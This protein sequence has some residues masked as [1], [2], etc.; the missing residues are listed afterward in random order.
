MIAIKN[1][2]NDDWAALTP[3]QQVEVNCLQEKKKCSAAS[4]NAIGGAKRSNF[5]LDTEGNIVEEL[6]ASVALDRN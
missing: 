5:S 1:Y 4:A 6:S 3:A 2:L